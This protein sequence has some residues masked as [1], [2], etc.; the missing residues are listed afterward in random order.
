MAA[1]TLREVIRSLPEAYKQD[2]ERIIL[3]LIETQADLL[4]EVSKTAE[5]CCNL[6]AENEATN[7][8][9]IILCPIVET[10]EFP[11]ILP[12]IK[13]LNIVSMAVFGTSFNRIGINVAC[14]NWHPRSG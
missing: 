6:I 10:V 14:G 8:L 2:I 3:G 5:E 12:A 13:M 4:K 7:N 9:V 11:A 1:R